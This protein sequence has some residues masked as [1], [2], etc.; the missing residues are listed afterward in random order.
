[1]SVIDNR[2]LHTSAFKAG[3]LFAG[4]VVLLVVVAAASAMALVPWGFAQPMLDLI[5]HYP[6]VNALAKGTVASVLL[7]VV[8]LFL[9]WLERKI[10]GWM[11]ARLGPMHVGWKGLGQTAADAVKLLIKE[12]VIP[13]VADK[14]LFIIAPFLVMVPTMLTYMV[15]PFS[16][17]WI[18][19]DLP[20][21]ALYVIAVS[22]IT[23]LG[24]MSAG[25]GANNKY[26]LLGGVR[27]VA[28]LLSYEIPMVIVILSVVT[29]TQTMSTVELVLQQDSFWHMNILRYAPVLLPGFVIYLVCAMA[30]LNRAPFDLP[31]AESELVSGFHTEYS[32]MRF[33]F[34]FLSEFANNFF[35]AGF[36]VVLFFGGWLGPVLPA[37]VWFT[38]KTV[39]VIVL[40]MWIRWTLPRLRIDQMMSFCWKALVPLSFVVFCGAVAWG[41]FLQ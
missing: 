11:Q 9:I 33:A 31:E 36:A 38:L 25:W 23:A 3:Q 12:D 8:V 1:M 34:F 29:L 18:G 24:I 4:L 28:Q 27:A 14:P 17:L 6:L 39:A 13:A 22:T 2:P 41:L 15:L 30:E 7:S 35:S 40:M 26:S 32:G 20:L 5:G 37:P 21:A 10:A 16:M 19:Y